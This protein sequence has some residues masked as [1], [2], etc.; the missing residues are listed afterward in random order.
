M[1]P[2]SFRRL[3]LGAVIAALAAVS[4]KATV[5]AFT[6]V[7]PL[8]TVHSYRGMRTSLTAEK[9]GEE[10]EIVARRITVRGD[11]NGGYVRTCVLNE[12]SYSS[13]R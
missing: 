10:T 3:F 12:V 11:V 9:N 2:I 5:N 6:G 8:L 1:Y 13:K 7:Q 4:S